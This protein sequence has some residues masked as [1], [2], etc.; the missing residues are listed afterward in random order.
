MPKTVLLSLILRSATSPFS[1]R[2]QLNFLLL[3]RPKRKR[4]KDVPT[5][6]TSLSF[7]GVRRE[8]AQLWSHL[9]QRARTFSCSLRRLSHFF[10]F[11][12]INSANFRPL[13]L[14]QQ[15]KPTNRKFGFKPRSDRSAAGNKSLLVLL[16]KVWSD[17]E[18]ICVSM[19]LKFCVN[20]V[21]INWFG[22]KSGLWIC[23]KSYLFLI[24]ASSDVKKQ[25]S[26]R[27]VPY[28]NIFCRFCRVRPLRIKNNKIASSAFYE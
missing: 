25:R 19:H 13:S 23:Q 26:L 11:R 18:F 1:C 22:A 2:K 14:L 21:F 20:P 9:E 10:K 7:Q 15:L 17:E 24:S 6:E 8:V 3:K 16:P 5:A 12:K 4:I 28:Y 27:F